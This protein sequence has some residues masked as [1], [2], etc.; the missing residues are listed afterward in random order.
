MDNSKQPGERPD[1]IVPAAKEKNRRSFF[2]ILAGAIA[3]LGPIGAGICTFL[4]PLFRQTQS[5]AVRVGLL[6]QVPD[7]GEPH[8]FSVVTDWQDAWNRYPRQKIG[9]VYLIR[10]PGANAP[11]AFTAKCP[12][13]GCS[14]GY[15]AAEGV[16][17]CP[18]HTSVF[19]IDGTRAQGD[20]EVAP[21]D[22][23][24]LDVSLEELA[25]EGGDPVIEIWVNFVDYQTG[26]STK[27]PTT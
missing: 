27:M 9:A 8:F 20:E 15:S 23:D 24:L 22:M 4:S 13:A 10:Q 21:R 11:I 5:P 25:V 17:K 19:N 18:C 26:R 3:M 12:H 2:A 7:D 6:S 1:Q 14:I 16:F